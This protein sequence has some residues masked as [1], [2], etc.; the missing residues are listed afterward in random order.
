M[1]ELNTFL[2]S[3]DN[4]NIS[5]RE[6]HQEIINTNFPIS[7]AILMPQISSSIPKAYKQSKALSSN[8]VKVKGGLS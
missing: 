8:Y 4:P 6:K 5:T 7:K 3:S 2:K 1:L